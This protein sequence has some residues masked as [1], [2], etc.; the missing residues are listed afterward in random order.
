M[1]ITRE[2][3]RRAFG[4]VGGGRHKPLP[5]SQPADRVNF[6]AEYAN[7]TSTHM[8]NIEDYRTQLKQS[9]RDLAAENTRIHRGRDLETSRFPEASRCGPPR[10]RKDS[11][12]PKDRQSSRKPVPVI[13]QSHPADLSRHFQGLRGLPDPINIR[14][15]VYRSRPQ[16]QI[17]W[18]R[19]ARITKQ[20]HT[21]P[22]GSQFSAYNVRHWGPQHLLGP[23]V[24]TM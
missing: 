3:S 22:C 20:R 9:F 8:E 24:S 15:N 11:G 14:H 17:D 7:D 23:S 18:A 4:R 5:L 19:K 2:Y 10:T 1:L 12:T 16:L 13:N 6:R 21:T